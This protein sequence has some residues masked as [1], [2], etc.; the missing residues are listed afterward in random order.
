LFILRRLSVVAIRAT[1][2]LKPGGNRDYYMCSLSSR[3]FLPQNI[4]F[5]ANFMKVE[6]MKKIRESQLS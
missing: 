4:I 6:R 1:L 5:V 3:C 2:N